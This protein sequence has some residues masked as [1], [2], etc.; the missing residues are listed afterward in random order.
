M[1][2]TGSINQQVF[3]ACQNHV[4]NQF[5]TS[6]SEQKAQLFKS[7]LLEIIILRVAKTIKKLFVS[8]PSRATSSNA[9]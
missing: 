9:D 6:T 8:Q 3:A 7:V 4:R 1:I 2:L 5:C